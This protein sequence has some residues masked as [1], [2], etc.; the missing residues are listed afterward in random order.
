MQQPVRPQ[1]Y[2]INGRRAGAAN[3]PSHVLCLHFYE[4]VNTLLLLCNHL[5]AVQDS[6]YSGV[7]FLDL[8]IKRVKEK[9]AEKKCYFTQPLCGFTWLC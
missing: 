4:S 5:V 1:W 7:P 2:H 3:L 6:K 8:A 9:T